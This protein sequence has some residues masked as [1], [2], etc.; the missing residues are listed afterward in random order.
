MNKVKKGVVAMKKK[1][2]KD[3]PVNDDRGVKHCQVSK[4]A[5]SFANYIYACL[6]HIV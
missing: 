4:N 3:K 1:H 5:G 2:G 6:V